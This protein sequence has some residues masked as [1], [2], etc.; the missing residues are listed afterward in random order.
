[1]TARTRAE[2]DTEGRDTAPI[3]RKLTLVWLTMALPLGAGA[4][5]AINPKFATETFFFWRQDLPIFLACV[6]ITALLRLIPPARLGGWSAALDAPARLWLVVLASVCIVAGVIGVRLV[7]EGYTLSLDEFM[8]NFDA[9]IFAH[10]ELMAPIPLAWQPY[11]AALQPVF[12][13]P[14]PDSTHWASAYLPVNAAMRA[15]TSLIHAQDLLNPLLSGFA[16]V[17]T[18][19]VARKLW[20]DQ[21]QLALIAAILLGGSAQLIVTG[22]TSYAMPAH[23]AF[24][25]AWLWLFLRGGRLGH[26]GAILAGFFATGLHEIVFHPLFVAPFVL[27]LWLERRWRLAAVYTAA[28]AAIGAFW[29]EW[30]PIAFHL[31]GIPSSVSAGAGQVFM[32]QRASDLLAQIDFNN[33][34]AM[35]DSLIRFV[36][37]QN[38]LTV[39]LALTVVLAAQREKGAVRSMT[40]GIG[41]TLIA[42]LCLSPTQVHGWGYRYMHGFLGTTC[43]L[44]A[45]A[46]GRLTA[47]LSAELRAAAKG[48]LVVACA[49]SLLVLTPVRAWQAWAYCHPYAEAN[50]LIQSANTDIVVV[51]D[52]G[53]PQAFNAGTLVR[54]DPLLQHSPRV[55]ALAVL[56]QDDVA[57]LCAK[58]SIAVFNG[59]QLAALG[60]D[61]IRALPNPDVAA[62]RVEMHRLKCGRPIR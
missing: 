55:L 28:Y 43:L 60:G 29:T 46:W 62:L 37:W 50:A 47:S 14:L 48:G 42:M 3:F 2:A 30:W 58:H 33:L 9:R 23:L 13:L 10:G 32:V 27:Q 57:T 40:W 44:A 39:P 61:T 6:A 19:G 1:M 45:W 7:F 53:G 36:T 41:L 18:Y 24:N 52:A 56:E 59:E 31:A 35:S 4:W 34:A 15:A 49:V 54:N 11:A 22:M 25:M 8:A 51:D 21:P 16:I 38:P 26:V 17:A 20:P 12:T 5:F